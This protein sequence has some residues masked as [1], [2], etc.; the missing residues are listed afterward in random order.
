MTL[1]PSEM[2]SLMKTL[3]PSE[4]LM[5]NPTRMAN[6]WGTR[7]RMGTPCLVCLLRKRNPYPP[8]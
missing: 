8:P 1:S 5:P 2:P 6:H 3:S 7:I 4:T